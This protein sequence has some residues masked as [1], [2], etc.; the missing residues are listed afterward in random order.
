[1]KSCLI[2]T[3][4]AVIFSAC[5]CGAEESSF[6]KVRGSERGGAVLSFGDEGGFD[7][8]W[9]TC[10]TVCYDGKSYKMWYSSYYDS[11]SPAGGIALA[12]STDG[13]RWQREN[14]GRAVLGVAAGGGFDG[15]QV[16][17]A[18]VLFDGQAY[19]MWYTGMAKQWH[20]SGFGFYRIGLA[21]SKD[22]IL[23]QRSNDG[24]PVLDT[25]GKGAFDEVQ[26]ATPSVIKEDAGYKMWYAAWSPDPEKSHRICLAASDDGV[27]WIKQNDGKPIGGLNPELAYAPAVVRA[28]DSYMLFYT[29]IKAPKGIYAAK[30]RDGLN[31]EMLNDGKAVIAVGSGD[32][33]D[34]FTVGHPFAL[35]WGGKI[36]LWYTGYRSE[37]KKLRLSIGLAE[38]TA[39]AD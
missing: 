32:D 34:A 37:N 6:H 33:F 31:W 10:P 18:E 25:G 23:W 4:S 39:A 11:K 19:R 15:G 20:E 9:V 17:G 1:M 28:G 13:I 35:A 29:A 8:D 3:I 24:N 26:A 30:S 22:G 7:A 38:T 2:A 12:T 36:R 14:G 21:E 27:V 5:F 16:M